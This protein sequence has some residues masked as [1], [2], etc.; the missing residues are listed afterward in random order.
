MRVIRVEQL[1]RTTGEANA[2]L[3]A[4]CRHAARIQIAGVTFEVCS[5]MREVAE[6]F[7]LRYAE[8]A[9]VD[10]PAFRYYVA[11]VRG[12][13]AFW[14]G[15][16]SSWRWPHGAL[17]ADAVAFLADSVL[18][19]ALVRF[20][21]QLSALHAAAI[22]LGGAS[23]MIAGG[24][25]SAKAATLI[26][27]ARR[28]MGIY[29]DERVIMRGITVHPLLRR[30]S[31]RAAGARLLLT[32]RDEDGSTPHGVAPELSVRTFFGEAAPA[33]PRELRAVFVLG[34]SN[35]CAGLEEIDAAAA[36]PSV[37]RW[38]D[39]RGDAVDRISRVINMLRAVQ[40]FRLTLG[41][42]DENAAAIAYAMTRITRS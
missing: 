1:A 28:G 23:A 33:Y 3:Q 2:K 36:L 25:T 7:S 34:A 8:H 4:H 22:E 42:A 15:H 16:A 27:C 5:D 9:G 31:V 18:I 35:Y 19:A 38:F 26:A 37:T 24:A 41:S 40:C 29:A 14:C 6:M 21:R 32:E 12:G 39:A 17:P 20:D 10:T 30:S 13:Y 11:A